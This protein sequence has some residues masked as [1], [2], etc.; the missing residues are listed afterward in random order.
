MIASPA[1]ANTR[2]HQPIGVFDSGVGG[3]SVLQRIRADLP[4]ETLLYVAD[5]GHAP[6]GNKSTEFI[7]R[8]AFAI[9]EFLL[10]Q[11]AKAVVVACNTATAAAIARLRAHFSLPIIGIEPALKPAVTA[12]RS[13]VVGILATG[14]T[15]RSDKFAALLD[16]HG[17]RARVM[18]Q[19]CPGLA[20]CVEHGELNGPHPR[21]LL[22]RYLEP[23]LVAGADTLVLGCTHYPFLIPLIQRLVGPDVAI[24]DPS[25][26]V[27]RQLHRRLEAARLLA[28]GGAIGGE[29]Y[30]TSGAPEPTARLM[31]RLLG[32]SVIVEVLPERFR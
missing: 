22:E 13:G 6:Y 17:H 16:Q 28:D 8:R 7:A 5:S 18:V 10:G 3:L 20:D 12:T 30:L 19:P 31:T 25:P 29:R 32:Q 15:V 2:R 24:L 4:H 23:L 14:H 9:T 27:A 11:D 1:G 21:A 26:A